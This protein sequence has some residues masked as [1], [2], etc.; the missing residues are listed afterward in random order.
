MCDIL[1]HDLC[2]LGFVSIDVASQKVCS[3]TAAS[4]RIRTFQISAD[5][6]DRVVFKQFLIDI[7]IH[8]LIVFFQFAMLSLMLHIPRMAMLG[9]AIFSHMFFI[10]SVCEKTPARFSTFNIDVRS[11]RPL[12]TICNAKVNNPR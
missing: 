7:C 5:I 6:F 1:R 8:I 3:S 2:N 9:N 12:P 4:I 11:E 10:V